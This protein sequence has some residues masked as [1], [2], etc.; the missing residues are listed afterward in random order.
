MRWRIYLL[1]WPLALPWALPLGG[2]GLG[3]EAVVTA[4]GAPVA[5]SIGVRPRTPIDAVVSLASGRDCSV[6]RLEKGQ[7]YCAEADGR[8]DPQ[9]YCTR[10]LGTATCWIP[11]AG[12][13]NPGTPLADGPGTLTARQEADR[14]KGWGRLNIPPPGVGPEPRGAPIAGQTGG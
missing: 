1:A 8:P 2:C 13:E 7:S 14:T 4:I 12:I 3:A 9:P 6:V 10:T 5:A 11:R